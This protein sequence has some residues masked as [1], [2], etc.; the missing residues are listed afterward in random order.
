MPEW[1]SAPHGNVRGALYWVGRDVA[2]YAEHPNLMTWDGNTQ[3]PFNFVRY[4]PEPTKA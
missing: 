3:G 4:Y 1:P 2:R